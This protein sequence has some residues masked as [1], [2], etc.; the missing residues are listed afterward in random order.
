[1][2][3]TSLKEWGNSKAVRIP[4]SILSKVG[5]DNI[6]DSITFEI[7]E[8]QGNIILKPIKKISKLDQLF[9]DYDDWDTNSGGF[10]WDNPIGNELF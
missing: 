2:I 7:I 8:D 10:K 3:Q 4:K 9:E 5:L 1:M 6:N